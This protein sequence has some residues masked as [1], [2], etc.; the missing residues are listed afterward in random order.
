MLAPHGCHPT[1]FFPNY[2]YDEDFH[3]N[4]TR[5]AR[6]PEEAVSLIARLCAAQSQDEYLELIGETALA[7]T[8]NWREL[9]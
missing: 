1:S 4:W 8:R 6:D 9:A 5:V 3:E 2:V 7:G